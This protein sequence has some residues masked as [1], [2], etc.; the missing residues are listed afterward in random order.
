MKTR[1]LL[2][3]AFALPAQACTGLKIEDGWIREPPPGS[4]VAAGF[5]T[6][7][8]TGPRPLNIVG[9]SSPDFASAM[10]HET[11]TEGGMSRM[12]AQHALTL[13]PG[14]KVEL[15][16]GGLHLML[17][18]ARRAVRAAQQVRIIFDCT[19][20]RTTIDLTVMRDAP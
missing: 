5:M 3:L 20:S 17:M 19:E 2:L 15:A 1:A 9:A 7:R 6:L 8:N 10:L 11:R 4:D 13:A 14:A 18:Q 16:P 12:I